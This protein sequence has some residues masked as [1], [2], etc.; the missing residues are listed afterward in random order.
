MNGKEKF[1][2][3]MNV[4]LARRFWYWFCRCCYK[5]KLAD[6]QHKYFQG[7][8]PKINAD[9]PDPSLILWPNLGVR[10]L[11]RACRSLFIYLVSILL[12]AVCFGLIMWAVN[13]SNGLK[14]VAWQS[15]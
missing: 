12:M 13:Y 11:S 8:W 4:S 1:L 2:R 10:T 9:L 3:A 15:S 5:N 14:T 6:I 7:K